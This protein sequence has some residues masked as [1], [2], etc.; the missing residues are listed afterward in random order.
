MPEPD[1]ESILRKHRSLSSD[2]PSSND[3][4]QSDSLEKA[5]SKNDPTLNVDKDSS[6]SGKVLSNADVSDAYVDTDR[7]VRAPVAPPQ[8]EHAKETY[9]HVL[10]N[11]L[12]AS[13]DNSDAFSQVSLD[14]REQFFK[15]NELQLDILA[16][17]LARRLYQHE[18]DLRQ[19][20]DPSLGM[21]PTQ[22][23]YAPQPTKLRWKGAPAEKHAKK[24]ACDPSK[25]PATAK[26]PSDKGGASHPKAAHPLIH[27]KSDAEDIEEDPEDSKADY[28]GDE[29]PE[30]HEQTGQPLG[31][32]E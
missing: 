32:Q 24:E 9:E 10:F 14:N 18:L 2:Y 4:L 31:D 28:E 11:S 25:K 29:E 30:N 7:F 22:A 16:A 1:F 23:L 20:Y 13:V 12:F 21:Y 19:Q 3:K 8:Q 27:R 15:D 6:D 5:L 26:T 17:D